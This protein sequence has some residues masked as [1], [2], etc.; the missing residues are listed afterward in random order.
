M[1]LPNTGSP[2]FSGGLSVWRD[3]VLGLFSRCHFLRRKAFMRRLITFKAEIWACRT[4]RPRR[5]TPPRAGKLVPSWQL[6]WAAAPGCPARSIDG[7]AHD[8]CGTA[9]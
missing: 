3:V 2:G 8:S 9:E 7:L 6:F 1:Q 4:R 5:R